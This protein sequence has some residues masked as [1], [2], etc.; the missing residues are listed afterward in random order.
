MEYRVEQ[1]AAACDV[2]VDTVRFYQSRGLLPQPRREGRVAWYAAGH[3]ER[4]RRIRELQ[5]QGLSLAVISRVLSGTL[6][7]ADQDLATAVAAAHGDGEEEELLTLADLARRSGVPA[8][9]LQ[10]IHS[11]GIALGRRVDGEDRYTAADVQIVRTGLRLLEAGLP[12][13]DLLA[14]G[15]EQQAAARRIAERAVEIFD[16]HVRKPVRASGL[17]ENEAAAKLVAA[18]RELLPAVTAL[19]AHH[20][21][22]VLLA[23]A[24]EHI[25][26][27]GDDAEIAATRAESRRRIEVPWPG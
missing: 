14:L 20:F 16:E 23:V 19:V 5:R 11:E 24:E 13:G 26:R 12:L 9:L 27:V 18:F 17:P 25:E 7:R 3:A 8:A 4:I 2:S 1:L 15:R 6:A 22:R 10:A 21:R